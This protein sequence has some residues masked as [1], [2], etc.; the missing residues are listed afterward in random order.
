V[1]TIA[2]FD[3]APGSITVRVGD[4][5]TWTN[6]GPSAHTA[7]AQDGSFNTGVLQKGA[8]ASH[9]FTRAGTFAYTCQI[10]PFMHGTVVVLGASGTGQPKTGA[11][12]PLGG[13]K[14][15]TETKPSPPPSSG[16]SRATAA[17]TRATAGGTSGPAAGQTGAGTLPFT[18]LDVLQILAWGVAL[19]GAGVAVRHAVQRREERAWVSDPN[20]EHTVSD[21]EPT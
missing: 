16:G 8:S 12:P 10:H 15:G 2:D 11:S 9:T 13:S 3:F 6:A 7:T 5:V 21:R 1:V 20:A 17:G 4:T 18:G 14:H 19:I